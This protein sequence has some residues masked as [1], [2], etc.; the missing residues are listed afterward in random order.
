MVPPSVVRRWRRLGRR[1]ALD[2]RRWRTSAA[3]F[4]AS[5]RLRR[6]ALGRMPVA[7]AARR[8][9]VVEQRQ[10][11]DDG[12]PHSPPWPSPPWHRPQRVSK[13]RRPAALRLCLDVG[14]R[15]QQRQG[16]DPGGGSDPKPW[17]HYSPALARCLGSAG[18]RARGSRKLTNLNWVAPRTRSRSLTGVGGLRRLS[19][20][21]DEEA[22]RIG[23]ANWDRQ[24]VDP[25]GF[26][27]PLD[28][29]RAEVRDPPAAGRRDGNSNRPDSTPASA[30]G[31][32][33]WRRRRALQIGL[34]EAA[35]VRRPSRVRR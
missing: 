28:Q 30:C 7:H 14:D 6:H 21:D 18:Q 1:L 34:E 19:V 2:A 16:G 4:G 26:A 13:A 17:G 15:R 32:E 35:S 29:E 11:L 12:G 23:R 33:R 24:V 5:H 31:R 9:G 25:V 3:H 8:A 27:H 22:Q 10:A 20:L